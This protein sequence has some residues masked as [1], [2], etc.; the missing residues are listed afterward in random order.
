MLS[1]AESEVV[2][3]FMNAQHA[4]PIR[5][6]LEDKDPSPHTPLCTNNHTEQDQRHEFSLDPMSS[7]TKAIK[8][9]LGTRKRKLDRYSYQIST[10]LPS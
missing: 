9:Y 5:L 6:N 1:A 2:G 8:S 7:K 4:V 10:S 3:R